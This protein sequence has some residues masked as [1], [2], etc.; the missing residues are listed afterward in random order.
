MGSSLA[1]PAPPPERPLLAL[2][3]PT[4]ATY[5][6]F[7]LLEMSDAWMA[8]RLGK[9]SLAAMMSGQQILFLLFGFGL[10]TGVNICAARA[11]ESQGGSAVAR[12]AWQG[13]WLGLVS[14]GAFGCLSAGSEPLFGVIGHDL[15]VRLLE[16]DYFRIAVW[17]MPFQFVALA[18]SNIFLALERPLIPMR[19]GFIQVILNIPLSW[20]LMFGVPGDFDG[21]GLPGAAWGTVVASAIGSLILL[22]EFLSP[23]LRRMFPFRKPG[24]HPNAMRNIIR[25]GLPKGILAFSDVLFW[26]IAL[27]VYVGNFGTAHMA[28]S[29]VMYSVLMLMLVPGDGM[30]VALSTRSAHD[31]AGGRP[32]AATRTLRRGLLF[33]LGFMASIGLPC[34][35]V[36]RQIVER[37]STDPAVV[38]IGSELL[39]LLPVILL[40]DAVISALDGWLAGA[41]DVQWP[42]QLALLS[43][44]AV[45]IA[46]GWVMQ[47]YLPGLASFGIWLVIACNRCTIAAGLSARWFSGIWRRF[48]PII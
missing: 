44:L 40:A 38:Q 2:A 8:G 5:F 1:P 42:T 23:R 21:I 9:E 45:V 30:N 47:L 36:R 22:L 48:E 31:L 6:A 32:E 15:D 41:G 28:A 19:S 37:F 16:I 7:A 12:Y 13:I 27:V 24:W 3:G 18:L 20:C 10:F 35:L 33:N 46:G 25:L 4:M 26:N 29:A 39:L 17:S 43:S 14:G 11:V 34:L